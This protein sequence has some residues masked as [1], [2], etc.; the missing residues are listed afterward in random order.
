MSDWRLLDVENGVA[1]YH[2]LEDGKTL[3]KSVQDTQSITDINQRMKNEA[4]KGWKGDIHHVASIPKVVWNMWWKELGGNP[5][6][7]E[8]RKWLIAR[9]NN[10][11][12]AKVRTKEGNL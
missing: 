7:K 1:S 4:D 6:A 3:I 2:K 5:M 12:W 10:K 9:L 11:D 8:N